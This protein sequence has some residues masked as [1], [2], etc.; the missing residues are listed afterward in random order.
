[1]RISQNHLFCILIV[2]ALSFVAGCT[3]K[4][5]CQELALNFDRFAEMGCIGIYNDLD[6]NS[7]AGAVIVKIHHPS[8]ANMS[9]YSGLPDEYLYRMTLKGKSMEKDFVMVNTENI[10][11]D[12]LKYQSGRFYT[13]DFKTLCG[14]VFSAGPHGGGGY[15]VD[16]DLTAM[17]ELV[18]KT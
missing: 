3:Q 7:T 10:S 9:F 1:M 12:D 14:P 11:L 5:A 17:E 8:F 15:F 4:D 6:I 13:F 16:Y 18:C 2:L